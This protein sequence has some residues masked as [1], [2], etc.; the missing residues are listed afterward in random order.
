[1]SII[2]NIFDK[3]IL[4]PIYNL[5]FNNLNDLKLI[6]NLP[7]DLK[8]E[9]IEFLE[10]KSIKNNYFFD[11]LN[12]NLEERKKILEIIKII[13]GKEDE[14]YI[15]L[16]ECRIY[17]LE[18]ILHFMEKYNHYQ[19]DYEENQ[20]SNKSYIQKIKG[21]PM[22]Y[23]AIMSGC[24]LPFCKSSEVKYN[25]KDIK[26][27]IELCPESVLY[28]GGSARCRY[29][30]TPLWAAYANKSYFLSNQDKKQIINLL[31]KNGASKKDTIMV[32]GTNVKV[33]DDI[34]NMIQCY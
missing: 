6:K 14:S 26:E 9:V 2:K 13:I 21:P 16:H 33:I 22:L 1:M 10:Q 28:D 27:I 23:D 12:K 4:N 20:R 31:L 5:Y 8:K 17:K 18:R 30:V 32:N 29:K 7:L 3:W 19:E 11:K 34:Q 25:L 24:N 15:K